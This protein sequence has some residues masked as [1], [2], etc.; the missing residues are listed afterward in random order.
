MQVLGNLLSGSED[1]G[2][3]GSACRFMLGDTHVLA[4]GTRLS[5]FE[6]QHSNEKEI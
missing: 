1:V 5:V 6:I 2:R 3:N 4:H